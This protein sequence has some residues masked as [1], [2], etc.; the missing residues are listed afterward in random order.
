MATK[1]S[2]R[3]PVGNDNGA[4]N[5]RPGI[6]ALGRLAGQRK[7]EERVAEIEADAGAIV[8]YV[9]KS[10]PEFGGSNGYLD[11]YPRKLRRQLA[12]MIANR[13]VSW[14]YAY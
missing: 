2:G 3:A 1:R 11:T 13:E 9:P 7:L 4:R 14:R 10:V 5:P 6:K 12:I 8:V